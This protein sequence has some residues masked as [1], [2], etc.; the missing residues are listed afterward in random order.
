MGKCECLVLLVGTNPLPNF[1]VC[2]YFL[3]NRSITDVFLIYSEGTKFYKGTFEEAENI[4]EVVKARHPDK[5]GQLNFH[6]IALSDISSAQRIRQDVK[7]RLIDRL[8][9][10]CTI[11]LNYTGGTKAMGIH[12]YNCLR[13]AQGIKYS[14]FSYLD[15][16]TY[17]IVDDNEGMLAGDLRNTISVSFDEMIKLH[18][19]QRV[20]VDKDTSEFKDT[21]DFFR[22]LIH[23]DKLD[24][25]YKDYD[26]TTFEDKRQNLAS[27][28]KDLKE[29]LRN[30]QIKGLLIDLFKVI[31]PKWRFFDD[32]GKYVEP[33][34]QKIKTA[35]KYIDGDWLEEYVY[36][37]LKHNYP[38]LSLYKNW[39]IKKPQWSD[40][41]RFEID[42]IAIK[43]YQLIGISCTT[44]TEYSLCKSKGFEI[45]LRTT[46]IGGDEAKAILITRLPKDKVEGLQD[47]L[48]ADTAG[49]DRILLLG[50]EDLKGDQL[51]EK[52]EEF[53]M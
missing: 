8:P 45:L 35:I 48:R 25:F 3:T 36:E 14:S 28:P 27:K 9:E 43:G 10:N 17:S 26:R 41:S 34:D 19:L 31:P 2:E 22:C 47:S 12:V 51:I 53:V 21:L 11:H 50:K 7:E 13:M 29:E 16:R 39:E 1:V 42:V 6:K 32:S 40:N 15:A 52:F 49:G 38:K 23:H 37:V 4:E 46:Q 44:S 24:D 30:G 18:G 5:Q 33:Q 20:N